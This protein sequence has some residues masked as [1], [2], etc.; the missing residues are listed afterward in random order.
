MYK[1]Q[2]GKKTRTKKTLFNPYSNG[3]TSYDLT[4]LSSKRVFK[5][6]NINIQ[7]D[8]KKEYFAA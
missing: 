7:S 1:L 8:S 6:K 5:N 2:S 4:Y 3:I